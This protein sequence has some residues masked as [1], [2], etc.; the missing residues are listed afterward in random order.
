MQRL[1]GCGTAL[2]TPFDKNG[3]VDY[4]VYKNLVKLQILGGV[5]F[6]VPLGTTSEATCLDND[7]KVKLVEATVEETNG[8]IPVIVGVGSNSTKSVI[9]NIKLLEPIGID[10]FLIVTPYYNKPTQT[11]LY[12]HFKTIATT[13]A[14]PIVLYNVPGR[15]AVNLNAETCLQL[16]EI[17]NIVAV[18]EASSNY[19]QISKIIKYAPSHFA[20]FSGNDDETLA[21]IAT[22]AKGVISVVSNIAPK[23]MSDFTKI[24]L[25]N[26]FVGGRELH[27]KFV[28]LFKNCFIETNPIP[29]K[30]G[31]YKMGLIE[32]VLRPPLYAA[33][34]ETIA[35]MAKTIKNLGLL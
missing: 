12:N 13:T 10:G 35:V 4:K 31:M 32:N 5:D 29:V 9:D 6:L 19:A 28:D 11:G 27:H 1:N 25:Q 7:E 34:E 2:V 16:A 23:A 18:K 24:L 33:T 3:A 26:D 22:G 21:L 15:T 17:K 14:K 8:K 20:V 30:A